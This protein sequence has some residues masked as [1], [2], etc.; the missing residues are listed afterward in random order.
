MTEPM[1]PSYV[2]METDLFGT[3]TTIPARELCGTSA[4]HPG[5]SRRSFGE[6]GRSRTHYHQPA[7]DLAGPPR[8]LST[9]ST[10]STLMSPETGSHRPERLRTQVSPAE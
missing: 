8:A 10:S 9:V 3:D 6:C 4:E 7:P 5:A 2:P 1:E